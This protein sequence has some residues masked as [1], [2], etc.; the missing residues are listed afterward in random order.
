MSS[1]PISV[2]S[3]CQGCEVI[4][5][6]WPDFLTTHLL[7]LLSAVMLICYLVHYLTTLGEGGPRPHNRWLEKNCLV[8]Y[9]KTLLSV[10]MGLPAK[11]KANADY[12]MNTT[13]T[14]HPMNARLKAID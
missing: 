2:G 5:G 3:S 6:V 7:T 8:A 14:S 4:F 13:T 11:V 12:T 9:G 10:V 1:Y